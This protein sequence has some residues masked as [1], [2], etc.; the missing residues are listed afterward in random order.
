MGVW[1]EHNLTS[2][3]DYFKTEHWQQL[4]DFAI[5]ANEEAECYIC[6]RKNSLYDIIKRKSIL[7]IHHLSYQNLFAE[8]EW[9]D[10]VILCHSCHTQAHFWTI[11][12]FKIPLK[13]NWLLASLRLRKS[14]YYIHKGKFGAF[15]LWS[16]L[17]LSSVLWHICAYLI[18]KVVFLLFK[19]LGLAIR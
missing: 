18:K 13:T 1:E 15:L 16:P 10:Y 3:P 7:V 9:K 12:N 5:Y 14:I 17:F 8:R 6:F 11:F 2:Y 4:K 19:I